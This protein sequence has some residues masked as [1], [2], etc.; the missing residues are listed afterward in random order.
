[1]MAVFK[2]WDGL[3]L[4]LYTSLHCACYLNFK[5]YI[6]HISF[7]INY[8]RTSDHNCRACWRCGRS[9][10]GVRIY[11]AVPA[12]ALQ[13]GLHLLHASRILRYGL[14]RSWGHSAWSTGWSGSCIGFFFSFIFPSLNAHNNVSVCLCL[15][16]LRAPLPDL[17]Q[18]TCVAHA[19][20]KEKKV[21]IRGLQNE[22][23]RGVFPTTRLF[24]AN[25]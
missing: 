19:Y 16:Y 2:R 7:R 18:D 13:A 10:L 14:W 6:S 20:R 15:Q 4:P 12:T 22:M 5:K 9:I 8:W 24:Y 25:F 11:D 3:L 23:S 1:M 17:S 21:A